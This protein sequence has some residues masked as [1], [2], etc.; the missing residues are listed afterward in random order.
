MYFAFID[1]SGTDTLPPKNKLTDKRKRFFVEACIIA[2][3]KSM[4][5]LKRK[6]H[7]LL[8][9]IYINDV[10][11][12]ELFNF[13]KRFTCKEPELKASYILDKK[14]PFRLLHELPKNQYKEFKDKVFTMVSKIL[15]DSRADLIV[16]VIDKYKLHEIIAKH[17]IPYKPRLVAMDFLFTRIAI[18]LEKKGYKEATIIHDKTNKNEQI[19][20]VLE[21]LKKQG[22]YYNPRLKHKPNY[23]LIKELTFKD[24]ANNIFL[25]YADILA[26][27]TRRKHTYGEKQY[28]SL[29]AGSPWFRVKV[30]PKEV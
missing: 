3:R 28:Y 30:Y 2:N 20:N 23:H 15:R 26:S 29:F 4:D 17:G 25:Q 8:R 12:D 13:Y 11:I 14:G 16:I 1:E 6:Y 21:N 18:A 24:S 27:L 10:N 7:E 19:R 22:Y 9:S 5:Y